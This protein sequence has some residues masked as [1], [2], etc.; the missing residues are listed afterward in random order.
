MKINDAL[1]ILGVTQ[2]SVTP[3]DIKKAYR[4][5]CTK[6]HPDRNPA[7]LEM[8]KAVNVAFETL[9]DYSGEIKER[10]AQDYG[11][12]LNQALN[13]IIHLDLE[14]EICGSWIWVGGDT[15]LHREALKEASF[16]W[17]PKKMRWYFR[18]AEYKS[19]SRGGWDIDK[20]RQA[21]GSQAVRFEQRHLTRNV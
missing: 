13:S 3:E 8:M 11:E 20:I 1:S 18:P 17:A 14:I 16:R 6:Y 10:H 4:K 9:K 12:E 2:N 21:H 7:G 5:A 19:S 15:K